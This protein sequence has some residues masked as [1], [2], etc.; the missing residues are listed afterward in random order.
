MMM[1]GFIWVGDC[2]GGKKRGLLGKV[3]LSIEEGMVKEWS[4][5]EGDKET[6]RG[7]SHERAFFIKKTGIPEGEIGCVSREVSG[8]REEDC[9]VH[10][11]VNKPFLVGSTP[12]GG[13]ILEI[14]PI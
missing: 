12:I 7:L 13:V 5:K 4:Q 8:G 1:S 14:S 11:K 6:V 10:P 9:V 3:E 2:L